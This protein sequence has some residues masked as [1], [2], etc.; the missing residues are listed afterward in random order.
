M[1]AV[2]KN[3]GPETEE[4]TKGERTR[5][6]EMEKERKEESSRTRGSGGQSYGNKGM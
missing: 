6:A 4:R 5:G 1:E 3:V 2:Q